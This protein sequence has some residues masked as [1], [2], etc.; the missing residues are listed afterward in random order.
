MAGIPFIF[1]GVLTI[2]GGITGNLAAIYAALFGATDQ[3][4]QRP[5]TGTVSVPPAFSEEI[6]EGEVV[7]APYA[8]VPQIP[9]TASKS[10]WEDIIDAVEGDTSLG[11]GEPTPALPA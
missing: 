7:E 6:S 8:N 1:F 4:V 11:G 3:L 9:Q 10:W 5:N 2:W